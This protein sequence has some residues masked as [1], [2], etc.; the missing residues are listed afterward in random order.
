MADDQHRDESAVPDHGGEIARAER[1]SPRPATTV[2]DQDQQAQEFASQFLQKIIRIRGVKVERSAFLKQELRKLGLA[3]ADVELAL[4]ATPIQAGVALAQL[5]ALADATISFESRKSASMSFAAGLPGGF[6]ML[7]SIPADITQ[8][9]VHAFRVMQK[10]AYLYG[11]KD[12]LGD[13]DDA[14]DETIGKLAVFLG[15]MMGVGGAARSLVGFANHVAR[16]ALQKQIAKQALTKTAWYGPV[17]Q[18]LRLIG[19][20]VTKDSFAKTVTKTV[21]VAGGILSGGMTLASL[22]TQAGRLKKSLRELPPPGVDAAE[23]AAAVAVLDAETAEEPTG[24]AREAIGAA[25]NAARS[26]TVAVAGAARGVA[27][28]AAARVKGIGGGLMDRARRRRADEDA[29]KGDEPVED[30]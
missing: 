11:W 6:A 23:Y 29:V 3:D 26:G 25:T 15:V 20:K 17:K 9:Y 21:P 5:D 13:L 30:A 10:L 14:D 2:S 27:G 1:L 12:F 18:T 19:I 24:G 4:T 8:Y 22:T 28:G 16:P 7:A